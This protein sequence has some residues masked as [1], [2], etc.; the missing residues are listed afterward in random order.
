MDYEFVEGTVE[1]VIYS[2]QE[3]GYTVC[4]IKSEDQ[5][6]ITAVGHMPFITEGDFLKLNGQW[7]M[8]IEY[9]EQFKVHIHERIIPDTAQGMLQFLSSGVIKGI[10][11]ATAKKIVTAF[12]DEAFNVIRTEPSRL[13]HIKGISEDKAISIHNEFIKQEDVQHIV[14]FFQKY[15]ISPAFAIK[16]YREFGNAAVE[17]IKNDPYI[18]CRIDG[19]GFKTADKIATVMG[20]D[21]NSIKRVKAGVLFSLSEAVAKG[22]TYLPKAI[23]IEYAATSL[24]V[25]SVT[26]ENAIIELLTEGDAVL[27]TEQE[28]EAI[29]L[30]PYH[31]AENGVAKR[32]FAFSEHNHSI[33]A[34]KVEEGICEYEN[35]YSFCLEGKQREAVHLAMEC[36][37]LVITGGPG[38]GKTTIINTILHIMDNMRLK[39]ALAAPTGRAAKRLSEV[40]GKEAKTIHR[41]LEMEYNPFN[42]NMHFARNEDKPLEV[43]ILIV[44]EMSM[45]DIILM[46]HLLKALAPGTRL[47]MVGDA[48][49]LPSVGAGNVLRDIIAA[50]N[51]E[52][53]RLTEIFRQAE[54]SMIVVN[55]H[56]INHGQYPI[57][58]S[59]DSDFF[60]IPRQTPDAAVAEIVN[61]CKNRLPEY[62][63]VD[64]LLDIQILTPVKK[65]NTG[66][67]SLNR[68]MQEVFNPPNKSKNEKKRYDTVFREGD[69]V[70]QTRNNYDI[71]WNRTDG[72]LGTGIFNGDIGFIQKID[73]DAANMLIIFDGDKETYY[74]FESLED[75]E[76]A[77]AMTVHKSQGNEFSAIIIPAFNVSQMLLNRNLFYTAVTRARRL[78]VMVGREDAIKYMTDNNTEY[79]RYSGLCKKLIGQE[80]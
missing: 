39:V 10:K 68:C 36:G 43:N 35:A 9:G 20:V 70:M 14:I 24:G 71:E 38:T 37:C 59:Q 64:P 12:G 18:L 63:K 25:D 40:C 56:R 7:V 3:N 74:P 1:E 21:L 13:T 23:L 57:F 58:N 46:N 30:R 26:V 2:N 61:L 27:S 47:I 75:L 5:K 6:I 50:N 44:D 8:H 51:I 73:E 77:Y 16:V 66:V 49:Q 28:G 72:F 11:A 54:K 48:D 4:E 53:V 52:V 62:L 34:K 17:G 42:H 22:H 29:Y 45:V 76:L 69:K 67:N 31:F 60:L 32:L 79:K 19:I 55:A 41:L 65:G 33:D 78:V 15:S 80:G